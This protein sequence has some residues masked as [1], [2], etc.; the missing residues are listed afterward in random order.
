MIQVFVHPQ[1]KERDHIQ[2]RLRMQQEVIV[3]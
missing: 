1:A 3:R 2:I